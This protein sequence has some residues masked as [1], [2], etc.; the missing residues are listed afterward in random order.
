[1]IP[2]KKMV[3]WAQRESKVDFKVKFVI[4]ATSSIYIYVNM[5]DRSCYKLYIDYIGKLPQT[6]S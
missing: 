4:F 1:M 6:S 5:N 3:Q 2:V